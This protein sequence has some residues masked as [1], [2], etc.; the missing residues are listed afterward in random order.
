[1]P[2]AKLCLH[3]GGHEP[4]PQLTPQHGGAP[5]KTVS[6]SCRREEHVLCDSVHTK[7]RNGPRESMLLEARPHR[8]HLGGEPLTRRATEGASGV[9]VILVLH[10]GAVI[11]S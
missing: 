2:F 4:A 1:M 6:G 9:L 11:T 3:S 5:D 10:L 7:L 8:G